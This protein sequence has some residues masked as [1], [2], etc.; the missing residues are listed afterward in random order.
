MHRPIA[1]AIIKRNNVMI[2]FSQTTF[3]SSPEPKAPEEL[4]V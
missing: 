4:I 1:Q 3:F 2:I